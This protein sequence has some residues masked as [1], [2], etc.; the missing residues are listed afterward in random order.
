MSEPVVVVRESEDGLYQEKWTFFWSGHA[1]T[2]LPYISG[3]PPNSRKDGDDEVDSY[4]LV[5]I[6]IMGTSISEVVRDYR[7]SAD[8]LEVVLRVYPDARFSTLGGETILVSRSLQ[9]SDCDSFYL[10]VDNS[11]LMKGTIYITMCKTLE[12]GEGRVEKIFMDE[13]GRPSILGGN[14][15]RWLQQDP[16][17]YQSLR[18]AF[19]KGNLR[20]F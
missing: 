19:L 11:G 16:E 14:F 1:V 8:G 17:L 3:N 10:Y 4:L 13:F 5:Y 7:E 12:V 18:E 9:N 20:A 15:N 6:S 2:L